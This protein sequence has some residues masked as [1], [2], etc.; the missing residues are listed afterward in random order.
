MDGSER[1]PAGL[2]VQLLIESWNTKQRALMEQTKQDGTKGSPVCSLVIG[3]L[4][5]Q[6]NHYHSKTC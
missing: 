6:Q 2:K 5:G 1:D 3:S 4:M